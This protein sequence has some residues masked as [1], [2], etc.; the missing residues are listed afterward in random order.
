MKQSKTAGLILIVL[1]SISHT[2]LSAQ[3]QERD[4][5]LGK[6]IPFSSDVLGRDLE[7]KIY[8]PEGYN[9]NSCA[10]PVLYDLNAFYCFTY[11]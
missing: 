6:T 4:I 11:D 3:P 1:F 5:I 7:I 10:Y 2:I 9:N 8:L